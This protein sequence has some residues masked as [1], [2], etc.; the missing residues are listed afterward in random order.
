MITRVTEA[1]KFSILGLTWSNRQKA[2]SD[3]SRQ[4]ESAYHWLKLKREQR[5]AC[6]LNQLLAE[7][8]PSVSAPLEDV[9]EIVETSSDRDLQLLMELVYSIALYSDNSF[10]YKMSMASRAK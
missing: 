5:W 10:A 9:M 3:I 4:G 8:D 7:T 1:T 6:M 2:I